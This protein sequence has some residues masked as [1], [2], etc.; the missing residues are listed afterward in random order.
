MKD[1][2]VRRCQ[3][4]QIRNISINQSGLPVVHSLTQNGLFADAVRKFKNG[5]AA[6]RVQVYEKIHQGIWVFNGVFGLI[7]YWLETSDARQVFKFKLFLIPADGSRSIST[8]LEHEDDRMIP[9]GSSLR[10]GS[11]IKGNAANVE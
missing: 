1:T 7:D 11:A 2:I 4:A 8:P 5:A 9:V 3:G 6:E 10:Y